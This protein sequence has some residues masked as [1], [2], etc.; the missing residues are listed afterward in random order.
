MGRSNIRIGDISMSSSC[1]FFLFLYLSLYL[2]LSL[3]FVIAMFEGQ[4]G[5]RRT[6]VLMI[7]GK[8]LSLALSSNLSLPLIVLLLGLGQANEAAFQ[9]IG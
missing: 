1:L 7:Y 2:P 4:A 8:I 9:D 6:S 5:E 3:F